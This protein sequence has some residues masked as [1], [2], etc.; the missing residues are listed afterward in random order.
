N[1]SSTNWHVDASDAR[2]SQKGFMNRTLS[3]NLT[4]PF[5]LSKDN[6]TFTSLTSDYAN[7]LQNTTTAGSFT[8][9]VYQRQAIGV[10]DQSGIYN[11]LVTFIGSVP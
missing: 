11:I 4:T 5:Q 2:V 6:S 9:R 3:S 8:Q 1:T 7:F 10:A